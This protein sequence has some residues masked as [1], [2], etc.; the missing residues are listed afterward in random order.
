ML[1]KK[2]K[3][4]GIKLEL[5]NETVK[6]ISVKLEGKTIIISGV[7]ENFS[8]DELKEL[9]EKNGGKNVSSVSSKTDYLLA[10]DKIGPAKLE[11][12]KKLNITIISEDE[13]VE[14]IS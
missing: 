1:I 11:K 14:L 9:I 13:F 12:A 10:G 2:I 7:F 5:E 8:R 3:N 6:K 4:A